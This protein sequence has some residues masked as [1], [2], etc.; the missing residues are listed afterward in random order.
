MAYICLECQN[1]F[2]EGEQVEWIERHGFDYG[3]GERFS[4]CPLCRGEYE[5]SIPCEICGSEHLEEDLHGGVC[6][7]CVDE[8]R[9]DF[10][11]LYQLTISQKEEIKINSLLA[12]LFDEGDIEAILVE[13][14]KKNMPDIDCSDY[15]DNDIE[16][17]GEFLIK[18]VK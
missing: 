16:R 7:E 13:H 10:N 15:I 17:F 14:I 12:S 18:E 11:A 9:K 6:D 1:I 3:G 5:K 8:Y 2:E 4:G